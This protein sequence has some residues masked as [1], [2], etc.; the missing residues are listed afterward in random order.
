MLTL[1]WD[2]QVATPAMKCLLA[3]LADHHNDNTDQCFPSI[4][5]LAKRTSMSNRSVINNT[6]K[7]VQAGLISVQRDAG[8][9]RGRKSNRYTFYLGQSEESSLSLNEEDSLAPKVNV[10]QGKV[11]L[12]QGQNEPNAGQSE[13]CSP[14]P[15]LTLK[16]QPISNTRQ[17]NDFDRFWEVYPVKVG[18]KPAAAIWKRIKPDVE[19]LLADIQERSAKDSKW[20]N[21]YVPNPTKYLKEERWNDEITHDRKSTASNQ[22]LSTPQSRG[23]EARERKLRQANGTSMAADA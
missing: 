10:I 3:S 7:L 14:E 12:L 9:G 18:E 2:T 22:A 19:M 8:D 21:G 4:R 5:R 11:N 17:S 13:G 16:K 1:A 6:K 15:L 20:I 23:R